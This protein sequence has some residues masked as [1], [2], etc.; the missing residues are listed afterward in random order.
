ML[1]QMSPEFYALADG[2]ASI[3]LDSDDKLLANSRESNQFIKRA[4]QTR[5]TR[6]GR[7]TS[8]SFTKLGLTY[9]GFSSKLYI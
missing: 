4:K 7:R 3:H 2:G 9:T 6:C 5:T 1:N 8:K